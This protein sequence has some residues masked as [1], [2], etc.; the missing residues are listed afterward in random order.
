MIGCNLS[1]N[2]NLD[3]LIKGLIDNESLEKLDLSDNQI[4]D[5]EGIVIVRYI[6]LQAEK[7]EN[8]LW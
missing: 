5:Q 6:K 3:L 2:G 7:R 1:G 4:K 8:A